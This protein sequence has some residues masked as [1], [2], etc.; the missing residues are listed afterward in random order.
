M[1]A[2]RDVFRHLIKANANRIGSD[3]DSFFEL[4][5][6]GFARAT[7]REAWNVLTDYDHLADFVPD[8]VSSRMISRH[9]QEIIVEQ[10]SKPHL[11]FLSVKIGVVVRITE[12]PFSLID[13]E[14]ASGDM[15]H[16]AVQWQLEPFAQHGISGTRIRFSGTIEPDFFVPPLVGKAVMQANIK[17][18]VE[19]VATEIER[20]HPH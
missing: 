2:N 6:T 9:E 18:M 17:K 12:Y 16:Y 4:S 20:R 13:V 19:S 15:K 8:L 3:G 5:A 14:L 11:A 7:R 10:V 1:H